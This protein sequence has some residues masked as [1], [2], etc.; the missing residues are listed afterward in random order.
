MGDDSGG[1]GP[2]KI[3]CE[4]CDR[5]FG[6]RPEYERHAERHAGGGESCPIDSAISRIIG[7]FRRR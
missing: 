5:V 2:Q 6:S 4:R 7:A 3:Y 1:A